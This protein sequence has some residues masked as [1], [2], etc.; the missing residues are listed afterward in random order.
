[1]IQGLKT[2]NGEGMY[3]TINCYNEHELETRASKGKTFNGED[4]YSFTSAYP[5]TTP[6]LSF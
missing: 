5:N 1:M 4:I 6:P 2:F 3:I